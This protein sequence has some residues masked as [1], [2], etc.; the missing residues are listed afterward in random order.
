MSRCNKNYSKPVTREERLAKLVRFQ[1]MTGL[2]VFKAQE[3]RAKWRNIT[4]WEQL[5]ENE[6]EELHYFVIRE[7]GEY[8]F[9]RAY[10]DG[11]ITKL[12]YDTIQEFHEW[13]NSLG[14]LD[15]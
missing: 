9:G 11:V 1:E 7:L 5:S 10:K 13:F 15:D 4:S 8:T 14:G 2:Y 6:L 3:L 12:Q